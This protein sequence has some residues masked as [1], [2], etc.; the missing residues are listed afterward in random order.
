[1]TTPLPHPTGGSAAPTAAR[2]H[3]ANTHHHDNT[4][5]DYDTDDHTT[6]NWT[7]YPRKINARHH[8]RRR[9]QPLPCTWTWTRTWLLDNNKPVISSA[10]TVIL[11]AIHQQEAQS[12]AN[13]HFRLLQL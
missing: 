7:T 10:D 12:A 11:P 4:D 5:T 6:S 1:M 2:A 9:N 13:H 3:L 8:T